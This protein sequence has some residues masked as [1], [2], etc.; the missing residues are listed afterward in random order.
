LH[1]LGS[2]GEP[3]PGLLDDLPGRVQQFGQIVHPDQAAT[4]PARHRITV[5][6]G[7]RLLGVNLRLAQSP[8]GVGQQPE[9]DAVAGKDVIDRQNA[10]AVISGI[11]DPAYG[12]GGE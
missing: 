1:R 10:G 9:D 4:T 7:L 12:L 8:L 11:G 6:V 3:F 2:A 5:T